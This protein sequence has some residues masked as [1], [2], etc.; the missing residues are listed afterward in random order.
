MD[1]QKDERYNGW[2]NYETWVTK[3]WLDND[4]ATYQRQKEWVIIAKSEA[5]QNPSEVFTDKENLVYHLDKI[6][7]IE[8]EETVMEKLPNDAS[9]AMDLLRASFSMVDFKEIAES[10]L[11]E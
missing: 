3:L 1:K 10:I 7:K 2:K 9:L 11:N 4:K 8:T 5:E 6:A